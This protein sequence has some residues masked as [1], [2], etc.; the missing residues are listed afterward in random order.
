MAIGDKD[1]DISLLAPVGAPGVLDDPVLTLGLDIRAI[2]HE[3]DPM[4]KIRWAIVVDDATLV[5]EPF[6]P[7]VITSTDTYRDWAH[8]VQGSL[9]LGRIL[10]SHMLVVADANHIFKRIIIA[11]F[12][13]ILIRVVLFSS[14]TIIQ[15]VIVDPIGKATLA[16]EGL[17]A[18]NGLL[19][20]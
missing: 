19:N 20:R 3:E 5:G 1:A 11:G 10:R 18:V 4:V 8:L 13:V 7:L 2:P 17:G 14:K 16:S 12:L 15:Y 6:E 9:E